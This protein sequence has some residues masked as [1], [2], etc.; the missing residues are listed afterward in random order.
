MPIQM[1]SAACRHCAKRPSAPLGS[2]GGAQ[3]R[4]S[5]LG[6]SGLL[7]FALLCFVLLATTKKFSRVR[8]DLLLL[9]GRVTCQEVD[10]G[11]DLGRK[12]VTVR[13]DRIHRKFDR[14]VLRQQPDELAR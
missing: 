13:I 3:S 10:E 4:L 5:L 11:P 1:T 9:L 14:A 8:V 2:E 6:H 7:R 12:M